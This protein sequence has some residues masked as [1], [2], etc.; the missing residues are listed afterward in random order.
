[1][2]KWVSEGIISQ[3]Q[4]ESIRE[5]ERKATPSRGTAV[6]V[7]GYFGASTA[8]GAAV[9]MVADIWG[10]LAWGSRVTILTV[11]AIA[12]L[13]IGV[14]SAGENE[15]WVRRFGQ[16]LM[17]LAIPLTAF[18]AGAAASRWTTTDASV[19]IG[20][21]VAWIVS[22]PLYLRWHS[23]AQQ[24]ALFF[25]TAGLAMSLF[26]N[27]FGQGPDALP[28]VVTLIIGIVWISLSSMGR[29]TPLL[30]GEVLG[31]GTA[32]FGS[33]M[34][35][36]ALTPDAAFALAG[37]VIISGI[38]VAW[39]VQHARTTLIVAGLVG[40]VVYIPWFTAD[41]FDPTF[42]APLTMLAVGLVLTVVALVR[43]RK[44]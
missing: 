14:I 16:V 18:A 8:V 41:A 31:A 15:P 21:G 13:I 32:L 5:Y 44:N 17:M 20:Y 25:A 22:I 2:D 26:L 12:L 23:T 35:A 40:M 38:A 37:F 6:E 34:V 24:T 43:S 9:I 33:V 39:G 29:V 11:T 19:L 7:L 36:A 10:E 28:G 27:L 30:T 1:M 4:A 42:A 3:D